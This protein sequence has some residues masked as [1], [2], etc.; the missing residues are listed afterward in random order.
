MRS[1][2]VEAAHSILCTVKKDFTLKQWGMKL[3][4]KKGMGKAKIAVARKLSEL[5]FTLWERQQKFNFA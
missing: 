2:L 5:L 3:K 4:E 1:L